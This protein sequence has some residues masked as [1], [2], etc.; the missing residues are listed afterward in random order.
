[1][2]LPTAGKT[3]QGKK[4][5]KKRAIAVKQAFMVYRATDARGV[6]EVKL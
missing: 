3:L 6:A 4:P 1:M 2:W 5:R